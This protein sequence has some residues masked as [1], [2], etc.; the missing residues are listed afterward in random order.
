MIEART[1]SQCLQDVD[2]IC[3][4]NGNYNDVDGIILKGFSEENGIHAG[5]DSTYGNIFDVANMVYNRCN[6]KRINFSTRE[7]Y[8]PKQLLIGVKALCSDAEAFIK[9]KTHK[10]DFLLNNFNKIQN[11]KSDDQINFETQIVSDDSFVHP[12]GLRDDADYAVVGFSSWLKAHH[13]Y[14]MSVISAANATDTA[15]AK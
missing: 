4:Y 9:A 8:A 1:L 13:H 7:W 2:K 5:S 14:A 3:P 15:Y 12:S 11:V 6:N 10:I